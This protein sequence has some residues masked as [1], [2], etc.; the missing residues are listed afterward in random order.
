MPLVAFGA[1]FLIF[2]EHI[3]LHG[4]LASSKRDKAL[5][6]ETTGVARRIAR[7]QHITRAELQSAA[8]PPSEVARGRADRPAA[9]ARLAIGT[10]EDGQDEARHLQAAQLCIEAG[11]DLALI[12]QW[13]EEGRRRAA[14]SPSPLYR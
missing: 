11:A 3:F 6:A 5:L 10:H 13:V 12:P 8:A 14:N 1:S 2:I 9:S 7:G 4:P